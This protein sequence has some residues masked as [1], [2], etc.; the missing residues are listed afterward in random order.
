[1]HA[2][3]L[4]IAGFGA[5]L[6]AARPA[7]AQ[8]PAEDGAPGSHGTPAGELVDASGAERKISVSISVDVPSSYYFRGYLL[9]DSGLIVQPELELGFNV[10]SSEAQS[11]DLLFGAWSS[12]HSETDTAGDASSLPN[13]Y[14][15]DLYAGA[16]WTYGNVETLLLYSAYTSPSDAFDTVEELALTVSYDD[17]ETPLAGG[18]ALAPYATA[19]FEISDDATDGEEPGGYLELGV[20]PSYAFDETS[21]L[22]GVTLGFPVAVG[23]S[24]YDYFEANGG[25]DTFGFMQAGLEASFPIPVPAGYGAW[26]GYVGAYGLWLSHDLSA[27]NGDDEFEVFFSAG[28]SFSF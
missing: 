19:V 17:T 27:S 20:Y 26:E 7:G 13:Y 11:V 2:Q 3:L 21:A 5:A 28:F 1:M 25:N 4:L 8:G 14:E 9:E 12:V 22:G 18:V 10:I 6:L 24:L 15:L 16:A 23:L